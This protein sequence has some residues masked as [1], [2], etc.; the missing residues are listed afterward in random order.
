MLTIVIPVYNEENHLAAC[1]EAISRQTMKPAEVIV[2]DNNSSDATPEIAM[3]Y[4]FVRLLR[5]KRQGVVYARNRGFSAA[6]A[7]L[8]GRIDGD[9]ILP[10]TWVETVVSIYEISGRSK[11]LALTAPS[12]FRNRPQLLWYALHR[13]TYFWPG[14]LLLGHTTF[15]GSNMVIS[16]QLRRTIE[17]YTC[18]DTAMHEDMDLAFHAS[19][20]GAKIIFDKR[21][22]ASIAARQMHRRVISYPLMMLRVK[23]APRHSA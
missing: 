21:L 12:C 23:L 11:T 14:R 19:K 2:V 22:K 6:G 13:L 5:E 15:V 18:R 7:E 3:K 10:D 4:G 17:K 16:R 8:I 20:A 9:T 1:L